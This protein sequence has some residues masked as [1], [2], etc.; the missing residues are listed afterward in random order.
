MTERS[1]LYLRL[2]YITVHKFGAINFELDWVMCWTSIG[3]I[4]PIHCN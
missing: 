3:N 2:A 1:I 4:I